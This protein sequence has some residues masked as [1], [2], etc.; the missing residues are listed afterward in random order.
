MRKAFVVVLITLSMVAVSNAQL[1]TEQFDYSAGGLTN[2]SSGVW[3]QQFGSTDLQVIDGNLSY[4]GYTEVGR[5]LEFGGGDQDDRRNFA[6]A[7]TIYLSFLFKVLDTGT[8]SSYFM[9][10]RDSTSTGGRLWVSN[11]DGDNYQIGAGI[12]NSVAGTTFSGNIATGDTVK[13]ISKVEYDYSGSEDRISLWIDDNSA[14]ESAPLF[15]VTGHGTGSAFDNMWIRQA[16]NWDN[17]DSEVHIDSMRVGTTWG[18]V[19]VIPEPTT[20][21]MIG[22][23]AALLGLRF[24][25]RKK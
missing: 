9:P 3:E 23:G 2:V 10:L 4:S 20:I 19:Q 6:D 8:G 25:R 13:V 18:D 7:T 24:V 1:F 22:L 15:V 14:T 17:G 11:V 12:S 21:A 5:M 16:D